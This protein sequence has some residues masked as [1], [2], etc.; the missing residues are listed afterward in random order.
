MLK[1]KEV[2]R[3]LSESQDRELP[4][5]QR[6]PLRLHLLS[7][8]GC[9]NYKAQLNLLREACRSYAELAGPDPDA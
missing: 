6:L 1:C 5:A 4:A 2:T 8:R 7:C 9:R 3:L